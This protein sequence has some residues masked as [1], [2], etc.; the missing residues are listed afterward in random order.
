[1]NPRAV[2]ALMAILYDRAAPGQNERAQA[3]HDELVSAMQAAG[4]APYRA[5]LLTWPRLWQGAPGL[6]ALNARLKT[7]LDPAGVLAPGRYGIA[8]SRPAPG[9]RP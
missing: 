8:P 6:D 4:Y 1:M 5:G 2:I 3:L 7:A 9:G